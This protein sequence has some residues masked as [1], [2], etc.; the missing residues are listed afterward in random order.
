MMAVN[1][2]RPQRRPSVHPRRRRSTG[3]AIERD[4]LK[5]TGWWTGSGAGLQGSRSRPTERH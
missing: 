5:S 4:P 1:A 3:E 2:N